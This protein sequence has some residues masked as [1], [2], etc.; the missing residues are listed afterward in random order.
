MKLE[1][2]NQREYIENLENE[3]AR[4]NSHRVIFSL[5]A[6]LAGSFLNDFEE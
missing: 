6:A 1:E 4:Y 5:A 3:N 2:H